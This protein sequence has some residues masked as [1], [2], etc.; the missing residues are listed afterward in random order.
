MEKS[1]DTSPSRKSIEKESS[2]FRPFSKVET[3][4]PSP[5][6]QEEKK[7]VKDK[8]SSASEKLAILQEFA[9]FVSH[10]RADIKGKNE[11]FLVI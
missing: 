3:S 4:V 8:R 10:D 9:A 11:L 1:R 7:E 5:E 6:I 2:S